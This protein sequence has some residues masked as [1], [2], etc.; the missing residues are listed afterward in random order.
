MPVKTNQ[1]KSPRQTLLNFRVSAGEREQLEQMAAHQGQSL[2][3]LIRQ[4]LRSKGFK[5]ER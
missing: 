4:S 3:E 1:A 2:S 5:P